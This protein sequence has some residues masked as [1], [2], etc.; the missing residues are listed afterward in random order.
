VGI[1]LILPVRT[2]VDVIVVEHGMRSVSALPSPIRINELPLTAL[3]W[4]PGIGRNLAGKIL[5][6]RPLKNKEALRSL[7]GIIPLEGHIS[8]VTSP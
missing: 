6:Q 7:A 3:K 8:F 5:A 4:I 2:E 1:P